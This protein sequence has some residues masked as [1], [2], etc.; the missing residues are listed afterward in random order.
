LPG[1][2]R[3]PALVLVR[4]DL[5]RPRLPAGVVRW[6]EFRLPDVR[7]PGR[8]ALFATTGAIVAFVLAYLL[9]R[10]TPLFAFRTVDVA[11]D[12]PVVAAD[13]RAALRPLEGRSLVALDAASIARELEALPSVHAASVDR[14]FPH[15]LRVVVEPEQP[16]AL[17]RAAGVAWLVSADDRVI[18]R[19]DGASARGLPYPAVHLGAGHR[20]ADGVT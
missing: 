13:V 9:A 17:V 12:S 11:G 1:M 15:T 19:V 4:P 20:L 2:V 18:R 5:H 6:P 10:E 14:E 16:L 3:K 8:R 7:K